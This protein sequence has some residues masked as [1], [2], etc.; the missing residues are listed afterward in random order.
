MN[1]LLKIVLVGVSSYL[2]GAIPWSFIMGKLLRGI[3]LREH[4]SGNLGAANTFRVLG[5]KAAVPV[6]ILD[7]G[8]GFAAVYFISRLGGDSVTYELLAALAVVLGHNYSI[9]VGFS[10]GKGIGTTSGAFLGLAP[11]AVGIC[12][13]LWLIVLL[14]SRIVSVASLAATIAL[15]P[16]ILFSNRA[17]GADSHY[18]ILALSTAIVVLV[19]YKHRSN[20]RR[21]R[22]GTEKRIF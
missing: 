8:K 5:T 18:S 7:I 22:E 21:L 17:F 3:D 6:L 2:A 1:G 16:A 10:G 4:G 9:F 15:P 13:A 12:F 19:I 11:H 14:F 20:I